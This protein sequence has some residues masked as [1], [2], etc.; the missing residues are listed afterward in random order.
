M[1]VGDKVVFSPSN[2]IST[3]KSI[4]AFNAAPRTTI[5]AGWSTGFTLT[6]EIYVTRGEVMS[7][8]EQAAAGVDAAAAPTSSGSARSRSSPGATT[9]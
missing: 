3:I 9:S 7:H 6:E 4:E 2:K 8:V 5:E 1:S